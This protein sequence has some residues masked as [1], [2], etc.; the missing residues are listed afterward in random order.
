MSNPHN[1]V[2][3]SD[4]VPSNVSFGEVKK[5]EYGGLQV[6]VNN[7]V[8]ESVTPNLTYQT[9]KMRAPFGAFVSQMEGDTTEKYYLELSFGGESPLVAAAHEKLQA[10]DEIMLEE[11][12]KNSQKWFGKKNI[13]KELADDKYS[14]C[15]RRYKDPETKEHTGK[16]PD[17][18]RVKIPKT[19]E[20]VPLVEVY[21]NNKQRIVVNSMAELLELVPKGSFV[22]ALVQCSNVWV[23]A[24]YGLGWRLLQLRIFPSGQMPNYSFVDD[25]EE[26]C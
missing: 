19:N 4:F 5:T 7:K 26:E 17:T 15:V 2:R 21:D 14:E 6:R 25:D 12:I 20:G 24:K 1:I 22:K 23:T 11:G 10:L 18:F 3:T 13:S 8:G 9:P 16:F